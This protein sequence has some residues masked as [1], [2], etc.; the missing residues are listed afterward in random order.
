MN[1]SF[2]SKKIDVKIILCL[3]FISIVFI[4][5]FHQNKDYFGNLLKI[6]KTLEPIQIECIKTYT[7]RENNTF[8][9]AQR[10]VFIDLGANNGD[11]ASSFFGLSKKA[12]GGTFSDFFPKE[13][14]DKWNWHAYLVEANSVFDKKLTD[15]ANVLSQ[16][17]DVYLYN[18]T[19]AWTYDGY[20]DFYIEKI[21][22]TFAGST[23]FENNRAVVH[24]AKLHGK[25]KRS[26][27]AI[28]IARIL[29][30]YSKEDLVFFKMDIEGAEYNILLHLIQTNTIEL[31]DYIVVE[32]H[33]WL[34]KK[35][36]MDENM[37]NTIIKSYGLKFL[38]WGK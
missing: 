21:S 2:L 12:Q 37:F 6:T 5:L 16:K 17:H 1:K 27:P 31:I 26:L 33:E 22:P 20:K 11:S 19:V 35:I 9:Q 18:G 30:K 32:Y 3:I 34:S 4:S 15:L 36:K 13:E 28:D 23:V 8:D 24:S 29:E 10:H 38:R 7:I 25:I 14:I